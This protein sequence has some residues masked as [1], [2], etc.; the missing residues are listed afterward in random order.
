M[1]SYSIVN[2]IDI[3]VLILMHTHIAEK[4]EK[5]RLNEFNVKCVNLSKTRSLVFSWMQYF[6]C[7]VHYRK[8]KFLKNTNY[9]RSQEYCYDLRGSCSWESM[10][11]PLNDEKFISKRNFWVKQAPS[12]EVIY[13]Y[14]V[15][16]QR[17]TT[18]SKK[19]TQHRDTIS[20][21]TSNNSR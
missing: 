7:V 15:H 9:G 5:K 4:R 16:T 12:A 2:R 19:K 17:S 1:K 20:R 10:R 21:S 18:D 13:N 3:I 6:S 8:V 11:S 14:A